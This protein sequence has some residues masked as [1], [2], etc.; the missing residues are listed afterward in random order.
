[1]HDQ[2][3][4]QFDRIC[5]GR[6]ASGAVLEIGAVPSPTTL[7][8]LPSL[9]QASEK[10]GINLD[11]PARFGD[12]TILQGN[13]NAMDCFPADRFD[14]VLCNATFEHD[15]YFWKT[16]AEIRRVAK[17]GALIVLGAPGYRRLGWEKWGKR[18]ARNLPFVGRTLE[19]SCGALFAS[20]LTLHVHNF[21]GDY[22]RF[23]PQA[24]R[25]VFFEGM[26]EVEV[27]SVLTPP[28]IIGVGRKT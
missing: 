24:F 11:P 9:R 13:G 26:K 19:R 3:Y 27:V 16:L 12:I 22:Y 20:T 18:L 25:E 17:P 21:P 6:Q 5:A 4:R 14:T 28:R 7:L 2:V 1:M 8:A 15:K 23:S 10:I